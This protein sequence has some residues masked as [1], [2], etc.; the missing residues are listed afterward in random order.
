MESSSSSNNPDFP[1]NFSTHIIGEFDDDPE[2]RK[3]PKPIHQLKVTLVDIEHTG[4]EIS[5]TAL[6]YGATIISVIAPDRNGVSEEIT[7][8]QRGEQD[9]FDSLIGLNLFENRINS[10]Y[11]SK[12][13]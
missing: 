12:H 1:F 6:S 10:N 5:L 8:C 13:I 11:Q 7:L 9:L 4:R 3:G 2:S